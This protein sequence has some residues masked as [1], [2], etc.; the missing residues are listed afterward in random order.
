MLP[1]QLERLWKADTWH[2]GMGKAG[3]Q[4][5]LIPSVTDSHSGVLVDEQ[6]EHRTETYHPLSQEIGIP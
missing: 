1:S 5:G 2:H 4:H 6:E 3:H